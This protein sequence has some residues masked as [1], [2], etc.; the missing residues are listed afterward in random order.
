MFMQRYLFLSIKFHNTKIPRTGVEKENPTETVMKV[1][2]Y[3][4]G[5]LI[6]T[7]LNKQFTSYNIVQEVNIFVPLQVLIN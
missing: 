4:G 5:K 7:Q 3:S 6:K 1:I 2:I